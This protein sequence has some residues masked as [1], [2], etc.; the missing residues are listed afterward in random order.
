MYRNLC[1][2]TLRRFSSNKICTRGELIINTSKFQ[3]LEPAE[4][5]IPIGA[6]LL[7]PTRSPR[8]SSKYPYNKVLNGK[9]PEITGVIG[10]SG[11]RIHVGTYPSDTNGCILLGLSGTDSQLL[12]SISAY[13][14]FCSILSSLLID[15]PNT[16]F[17][18]FVTDENV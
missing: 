16:F 8:F 13:N 17:V 4:P 7:L 15:N 10:H 14:K 18:L 1:T 12:N 2:I 11:V 3:T 6:Y 9:V 5:I